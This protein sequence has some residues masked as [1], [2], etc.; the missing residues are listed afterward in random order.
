MDSSDAFW[1]SGDLTMELRTTAMN[2]SGVM[3]EPASSVSSICAR[4]SR[5]IACCTC[6][7]SATA[8]VGS[9][10]LMRQTSS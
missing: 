1:M 9:V 8:L 5:F 3:P 7:T 10:V 4:S 6:V 2:R